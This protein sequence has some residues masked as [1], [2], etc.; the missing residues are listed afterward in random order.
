M[1]VLRKILTLFFCLFFLLPSL[2]HA[3]EK[4][5]SCQLCGMWIDQYQRTACELV[6][7]DGKVEHTCGVACMLRIVQA[8]GLDAFQS[9]RVKDW[10]KGTLVNVQDAWYSIGSQLIPDML[11]NYIAFAERK[12]AEAF[13]AEKG[14]KVLNFVSAMEII[15]PRGQTQP[16][17]I[18]QAVTP[19][20]GSL[21]MG[22]AYAYM[23]KDQVKV[24]TDGMDP[25]SFIRSNP[26]QPRAPQK[27]TVQTQS[28]IVNY[29]ITDRLAMQ[30]NL[31]YYE[32]SMDTLV[33]QGKAIN[34][35]NL[36][37]DG[38]GD[39]AGELRYNLWR[40]PF[41]DRFLTL[42]AGFTLPTGDFNAARAFN[43]NLNTN[44]VSTAPGM[45]MGA[46]TPTYLGGLLYSHKWES[47]WFHGQVVYRVSPE[48]H[49]DYK[50][51]NEWQGG[52]AVHYTPHYDVML[53]IEMDA[54]KAT[55]NEDMGI[56][57]GNTGGTRANLAFVFDWR[58][59]NALGGNFNLRG[60]AGIPIYEDLNAQDYMNPAGMRYTQAQIGEG[61]FASLVITFNTRFGSD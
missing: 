11:P 1:P 14:G 9:I 10:N 54:A 30:V 32:K 20:Q 42:L 53:G 35:V 44:L 41:Y 40:S 22:V 52:I 23:E 15:S 33:R 39:L 43:A 59:F 31:P 18:R 12:D 47:F 58:F 19:G 34:S 13:A 25:E 3:E 28:V 56:D 46:G 55:R 49:S 57:I 45:Q 36:E 8:S 48:N 50:F 7:K 5:E 27:M 17:R 38:I 51:G 24:G 4:R 16:F 2:T 60:S 61:F 26:A 37:D 21:G 29:G 6:H